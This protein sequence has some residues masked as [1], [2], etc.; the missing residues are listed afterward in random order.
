[1]YIYIY[2]YT[3]AHT[4]IHTDTTHTHTY[5]HINIYKN[6]KNVNTNY[7]HTYGNSQSVRR[8]YQH[9]GHRRNPSDPTVFWSTHTQSCPWRVSQ[10]SSVYIQSY[11]YMN[12][13]VYMNVYVRMCMHAYILAE[14]HR[15]PYI[16]VSIACVYATGLHIYMA[17]IYTCQYC[18]CIRL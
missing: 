10:L 18:L 2:I 14:N 15:Y 17:S 16:H 7:T 8:P 13:N 12:T 3:R 4:H 11:V 9:R 5:I 1:M 6:A